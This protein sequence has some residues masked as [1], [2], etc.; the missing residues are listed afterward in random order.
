M[1]SLSCKARGTQFSLTWTDL[2]DAGATSAAMHRMHEG[3]ARQM[4][5]QASAPLGVRGITSDPEAF[6]QAF[7]ARP[8]QP[9]Q[10]VRQAVFS[11]GGRLYQLLMQGERL[12]AEAWD[13]FL[14]SVELPP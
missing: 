11:R 5:A 3:I 1:R 2:G 7:E 6:Q 10:Q 4:A 12:D 8:G 13:V 14:G 9:R